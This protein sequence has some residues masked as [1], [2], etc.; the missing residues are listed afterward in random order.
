M[1]EN[2]ASASHA[3]LHIGLVL[4]P[5]ASYDTFNEIENNLKFL[6]NQHKEIILLGDANCDILPNFFQTSYNSIQL[7]TYLILGRVQLASLLKKCEQNK[8][9]AIVKNAKWR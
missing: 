9:T 2:Q 6:D 1:C 8:I 5:D 7:C 4:P 3:F